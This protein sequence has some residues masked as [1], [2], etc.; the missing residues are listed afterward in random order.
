MS[1]RPGERVLHSASKEELTVTLTPPTPRLLLPGSKET[2][3][4]GSAF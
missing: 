1:A 4:V 2:L 3:I